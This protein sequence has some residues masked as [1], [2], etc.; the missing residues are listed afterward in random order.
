M[1]RLAEHGLLV[2]GRVGWFHGPTVPHGG[3]MPS[4][5]LPRPGWGPGRGRVCVAL[6]SGLLGR[7]GLWCQAAT[8]CR[9]A[10]SRALTS[11]A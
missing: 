11:R 1:R 4:A 8:A 2:D 10:L 6:W 7:S 5:D 9:S 3:R